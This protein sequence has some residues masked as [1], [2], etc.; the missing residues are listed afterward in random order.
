MLKS[1]NIFLSLFLILFS[2]IS[3]AEIVDKVVA[4]VNSEPI[5]LSDIQ[6]LSQRLGREGAVDEALL[7]DNKPESLKSDSNQ[8]LEY[9]IREKLVESEIKKQNLT[10][11]DDRIESEMTTLAR[12]NQMTRDQLESFIKKQGYT[13]D[14][15]KKILKGRIERQSFFE[16]EI[17][18]KLRITD[19]D[20]YSLYRATAPNYKPNVNEFTLA[21]IFFDPKKGSAAEA[22][23]RA[24]E[25]RSKIVAGESFEVLANKFNEDPRASKDG[26]LGSFKTGE[27]IPEIEKAIQ[28]LDAGQVSE[29]A[30]SKAGFHIVKVLDKKVTVD[31]QFLRVKEQIKASLVEKN[32]KRQL[33]NWFESK[34]Q[35]AYIKIN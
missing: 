4:I 28:S 13:V 3:S 33:K 27:F 31:P 30:Q 9:L 6:S 10:A 29:V 18:S 17:I 16:N 19:E 25:V 2:I 7:L 26:A 12:R 32:F 14:E 24:D 15:Y 35:D 34:K 20:A 21:Q 1:T 23:K 11:S 8:Q 22:K 5:L